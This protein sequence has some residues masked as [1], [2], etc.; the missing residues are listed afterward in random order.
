M[1]LDCCSVLKN[2]STK[3]NGKQT[4]LNNDTAKGFVL[5]FNSI[6]S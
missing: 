5:L 4:I 2:V 1:R 3:L 6:I